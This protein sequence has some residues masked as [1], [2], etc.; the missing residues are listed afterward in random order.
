MQGGLTGD[1]YYDGIQFYATEGTEA[2]LGGLRPYSGAGGA[3][4]WEGPGYTILD[5][6]TNGVDLV[7]GILAMAEFDG[8]HSGGGEM[9][10]MLTNATYLGSGWTGFGAVT[11]AGM[12]VVEAIVNEVT[13]GS[14]R[15]VAQIAIR[16]EAMTPEES[17]ALT[18]A[19]SELPSIEV[20]PLGFSRESNVTAYV[21]FGSSPKS[22][23][24]LAT[25]SNLLAG[26]WGVLPGTWNTG[27]NETW[28]DVPLTSIPG[29]G[30]RQGF[31]YG[32][33]A[34]Y[35]KMTASLFSG[36]MR[37]AVTHT[38]MDMQ[39]WLDFTGGTG[40]WARVSN[41]VPVESGAITW[42][43][44]ELGTANSLHLVLFIGLTAYH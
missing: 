26:S 44:Q 10:L 40:M 8:P 24:C 5:E 41:S 1:A 15:V 33:Q 6:T 3:E 43:G 11:G 12:A 39:Y 27:T 30:T 21:S 37:M 18:A 31:L 14:G 7:R 20:M 38:G 42:V 17:D 19:S 4:Y 29:I 16:D 36:K 34:V 35:P 22:R 13:N 9:A 2:L 25:L 23:A 32:S 28:Q